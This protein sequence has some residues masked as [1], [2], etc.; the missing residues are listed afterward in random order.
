MNADIAPVTL[1]ADDAIELREMLEFLSD[2]LHDPRL[3]D[4]YRRF[5]FGLLNI[6][7]LRGDLSRFA[8]LLGGNGH[9]VVDDEP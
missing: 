4:S 6:D 5:T 8:F 2:W 1:H 9:L 3:T 7:E